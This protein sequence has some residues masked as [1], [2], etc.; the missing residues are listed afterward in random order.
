MI[1][2]VVYG[3]NDSHGYNLTKRATLSLNS[4]AEALTH[5]DDE[6]LFVDWNTERGLPP[7]PLT[8]QDVLTNKCRE[9]LHIIR[10]SPADHH[11]FA[12]GRTS[13]PTIEPVA[14]NVAIRRAKSSNPWILSTNTDVLL[15]IEGGSLSELASDLDGHYYA[16]PRY[17]LPEWL[18]E[19]LPR[20]D[21]LR[22]HN[23]LEKFIQGVLP[24]SVV[25]SSP[26]NGFDAPGDFQLMRRTAVESLGCFDETMVH[27]WHVDSNL[28][29][30]MSMAFG[31]PQSLEE[32]A[33]V[34]HCNHTRQET[35]FHASNVQSNDLKTYVVD[36][37]SEI[38]L[39]GRSDWGLPTADIHVESFK[40]LEQTMSNF[41]R[42][43]DQGQRPV[44]RTSLVNER[45]ALAGVPAEISFPFVLDQLFVLRGDPVLYLGS[46][47]DMRGLLKQA[48]REFKTP[49]FDD[50]VSHVDNLFRR[51]PLVI[52][53]LVPP[54]EVLTRS[55]CRLVE[56][57]PEDK[58]D[59][60]RTLTD[61]RHLLTNP[62]WLS[63]K[64]RFLFINAEGNEFEWALRN[65]FDFLPSQFYS[66]V[67]SGTLQV[68]LFEGEFK[69]I[70]TPS[71]AL[72]VTENVLSNCYDLILA[73]HRFII[74][75]P[76]LR[77]LSKGPSCVARGPI[78]KL[79][80]YLTAAQ[81][82]TLKEQTIIVPTSL[83]TKA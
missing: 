22:A 48:C 2:V 56:L 81:L 21:P 30:R 80:R 69:T 47:S 42:S 18:W 49:F 13:R 34:F 1:S 67:R 26:A 32:A 17:E 29:V 46:R 40:E 74:K 41:T 52:L 53:D 83:R 60:L 62:N 27:G 38:A 5:P 14:R 39:S 9:L 24:L 33:Q 45:E 70:K 8:I 73:A 75:H 76:H 66:R 7:F 37:S 50:S 19:Q 54:R 6:I 12:G 23:E 72:R 58:Q 64:P 20:A 78:G 71:L 16:T 31:E 57:Q 77:K 10:V 28:A 68:N 11:E 44:F 59:L 43:I 15:R 82:R 36:V 4:L 25:H 63:S 35:H 3:R 61:F 55:A 51:Q 79:E 65:F